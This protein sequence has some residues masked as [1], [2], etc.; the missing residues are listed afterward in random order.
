MSLVPCFAIALLF[1]AS[2]HDLSR[3]GAVQVQ[4]LPGV[5]DQRKGRHEVPA[6]AIRKHQVAQRR[7][8]G[9]GWFH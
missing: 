6:I 8:Q 5:A 1:F 2:I 7:Q 4:V 9:G 3:A